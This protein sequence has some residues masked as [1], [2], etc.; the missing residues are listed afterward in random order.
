LAQA[1]F[2]AA[3]A[4][5]AQAWQAPLQGESQHT[6]SAQKPLLHWVSAVQVVPSGRLET[7]A[8]PLQKFPG[9]HCASEE[10]EVAQ[11]VLP[12]Q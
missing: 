9:L 6:P 12:L 4:A 8:P 3:P 11:A 7:Q 5:T 1:P 10:Q 2:C